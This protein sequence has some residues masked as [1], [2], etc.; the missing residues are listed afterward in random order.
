MPLILIPLST[1]TGF[2]APAHCYICLM[3]FPNTTNNYS[4]SNDP[5]LIWVFIIR[6]ESRRGFAWKPPASLRPNMGNHCCPSPSTPASLQPPSMV[7][8][9]RLSSTWSSSIPGFFTLCFLDSSSPGSDEG[10]EKEAFPDEQ[11]L[12]TPSLKV[13]SISDLKIAPRDFKSLFLV[14]S[15]RSWTVFK[16][17]FDKQTLAPSKAGT[18]MVAVIKRLNPQIM[19]HSTLTFHLLRSNVAGDHH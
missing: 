12:P 18:G 17:W 4:Y 10:P 1:H 19:Q 14:G 13:L 8:G 7:S 6:Q 16:S 11:I 3:L 2:H 5:L 15:G 9:T